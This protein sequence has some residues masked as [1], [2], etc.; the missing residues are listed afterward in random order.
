M[1]ETK[2]ERTIRTTYKGA[3]LKIGYTISIRNTIEQMIAADKAM[4]SGCKPER[5]FL[6]WKSSTKKKSKYDFSRK[7]SIREMIVL[8]KPMLNVRIPTNNTEFCSAYSIIILNNTCITP[9]LL[10][11]SPLFLFPKT[12]NL[13]ETIYIIH[14]HT[15]YFY[16]NLYKNKSVRFVQIIPKV[17]NK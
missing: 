7:Y 2:R 15:I 8:K 10:F 9:L 4:N 17:I 12:N 1:I 5:L 11:F 13:T 16:I 3:L 6:R 14:K